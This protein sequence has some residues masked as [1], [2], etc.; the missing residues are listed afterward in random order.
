[1]ALIRLD[2]VVNRIGFLSC[3]GLTLNAF[4]TVVGNRGIVRADAGG[5]V[6]Y[7]IVILSPQGPAVNC[8]HA[9]DQ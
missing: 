9:L 2:H 6:I 5:I 8:E 3:N 4:N 7:M 1:M